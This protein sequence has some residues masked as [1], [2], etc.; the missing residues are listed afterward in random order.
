MRPII[1]S[2]LNE[3]NEIETVLTIKIDLNKLKRVHGAFTVMHIEEEVRLQSG[4][5]K[6][7]VLLYRDGNPIKDTPNTRG[8]AFVSINY[9][10]VISKLTD[11]SNGGLE[12]D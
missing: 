5:E 9:D 10:Q 6:S 7:L 1:F 2:K 8:I 4:Y 12:R 11:V 3:D